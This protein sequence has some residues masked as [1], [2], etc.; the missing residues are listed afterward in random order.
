MAIISL[1]GVAPLSGELPLAHGMRNGVAPPGPGAVSLAMY[2]NAILG[3]RLKVLFRHV[4]R[5]ADCYNSVGSADTLRGRFRTSPNCDLVIARHILLPV[6]DTTTN[7]PNPRMFWT[8]GGV[9]QATLYAAGPRVSAGAT[10]VPD[11]FVYVDQIWDLAG[12]TTY[13]AVLNQ[14]DKLR[15]I[16][17]TVYE[18][19]RDT[20]DTA[21]DEAVDHTTPLSAQPIFDREAADVFQAIGR[22]YDRQST[23]FVSWTVPSTTA[24]TTTSA[25]YV[26]VLDTSISAVG[27]NNPGW[28]VDPRYH[29][30]WHTLN[31]GTSRETVPIVLAAYLATSNA[32]Q[33]V[34]VALCDANNTT[35]APIA[36]VTRT[37]ATTGA[38]VATTTNW[39][40]P[41]N[42]T[43]LLQ[44]FMKITGGATASVY[45]IAVYRSDA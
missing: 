2:T 28:K 3:K 22:L 5:Q 18:L 39:S 44:P 41:S 32:G 12:A 34:T 4:H 23:N 26:N 19:L 1:P 10:V 36:T 33:T 38:W 37:G 14:T 42:G 31:A 25:S 30:L 7:A 43:A 35:A 20:L 40:A 11:E 45:A 29:G 15:C 21:T 17:V 9:A 16:G 6:D 13:E 27:A 24:R 8:V